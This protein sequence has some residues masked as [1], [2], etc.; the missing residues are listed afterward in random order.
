MVVLSREER[1]DAARIGEGETCRGGEL[2][3]GKVP[4]ARG[5]GRALRRVER[6][7]DR[8]DPDGDARAEAPAHDLPE[9][10]RAGAEQ[11]AREEEDGAGQ[12]RRAPPERVRDAPGRRR[13][14]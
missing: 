7:G 2:R 14:R 11:G 3:D 4:P 1:G 12:E 8:G 13:P 6:D 9:G 10:A 5:G